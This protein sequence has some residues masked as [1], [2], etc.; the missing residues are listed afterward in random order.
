MLKNSI[1][2]DY[3]RMYGGWRALCK[4]CYFRMSVVMTIILY[5]TWSHVGWWND[6]L[7]LMPNL[8]GFSLGGFAM[9]IAIG[10][11]NFRELISG[12]EENKTSPYM[13]VNAAFVHFIFLQILSILIGLIAK[14]YCVV[15]LGKFFFLKQYE[16]IYIICLKVVSGLGYF[17]FVYAIF[18]ALAAV[19]AI[20]RVSKWYDQYSGHIR[21]SKKRN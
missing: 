12:S 16:L 14:S 13:E 5:P 18:S 10:D 4:S 15:L 19:F 21:K 6:I 2:K 8:L 9:W 1:L 11:D 3:W 20:F 17:I 7:S